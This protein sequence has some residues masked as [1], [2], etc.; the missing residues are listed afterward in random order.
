MCCSYLITHF[1]EASQGQLKNHAFLERHEISD[2]FENK[3]AWSVKIAVTKVR[4]D[5]RILQ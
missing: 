5:E 1:Q 2:V 3:E 4:C